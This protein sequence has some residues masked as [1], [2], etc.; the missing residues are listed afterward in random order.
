MTTITNAEHACGCGCDC[1]APSQLTRE[2][3]LVQ[4]RR[5]RQ[6]ADERLKEL[7]AS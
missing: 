5:L 3:E 1:C 4:L 7:E 6:S 2:E